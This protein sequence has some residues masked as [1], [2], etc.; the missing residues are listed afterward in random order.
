MKYKIRNRMAV[1]PDDHL[2]PAYQREHPTYD[3]MFDAIYAAIG[4]YAPDRYFVDVGANVGDTAIVMRHNAENPI[5]CIEGYS[6]FLLYLRENVEGLSDIRIAP[7]F[8][9][10]D[11]LDGPVGFLSHGGTGRLVV[12]SRPDAEA[13]SAPTTVPLKS[14]LEAEGALRSGIALFKT[15]T[16]GMDAFILREFLKLDRRDAALFFECDV[17]QTIL[18]ERGQT[19]W[20]AVFGTLRDRGYSLL[21]FD[22]YGYQIASCSPE[23]YAVVTGLIAY[24]GAQ[25]SHQKV[26]VHYLDIWAFPPAM[27]AIFEEFC[28]RGLASVQSVAV[29]DAPLQ[30]RREQNE[31][32]RL[33]VPSRPHGCAA[34]D[35]QAKWHAKRVHS[36]AHDMSDDSLDAWSHLRAQVS[37]LQVEL[38][39]ATETIREQRRA[40]QLLTADL[41]AL[42]QKTMQALLPPRGNWRS[43]A[44][45]KSRKK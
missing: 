12:G 23:Q 36:G 4:A 26:H 25:F 10:I 35:F 21:I 39:R 40:I 45:W 37:D 28:R 24:I 17:R 29:P 33:E 2:L 9:G 1:L 18:E 7:S 34:A 41:A 44:L 27:A 5:L 13:T 38:S 16:D 11:E 31:S 8:V 14:I 32:S 42:K 15:D 19:A 30:G 43:V 3:M 20:R 6:R 22:N